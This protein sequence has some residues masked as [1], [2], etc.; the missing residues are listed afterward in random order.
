MLQLRVFISGH[1][2][3]CRTPVY[4]PL[5]TSSKGLLRTPDVGHLILRGFELLAQLGPPAG[6]PAR[7]EHQGNGQGGDGQ[8][9]D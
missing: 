5:T 6:Q 9:T 8:S 7:S 4:G 2:N 1:F 3:G